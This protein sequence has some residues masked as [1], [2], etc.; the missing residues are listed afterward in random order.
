[1][2]RTGLRPWE[3]GP[4]LDAASGSLQ[5]YGPPMPENVRSAEPA[6]AIEP[7]PEA[8]IA[9]TEAE[10]E[11]AEEVSSPLRLADLRGE[12]RWVGLA[13][14][15]V[16]AAYAVRL[17]RQPPQPGPL[18]EPL[19]WLVAGGLIFGAATAGSLPS[20]RWIP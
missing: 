14:A 6:L 13:L 8:A 16:C 2:G 7:P 4:L 20:R 18:N 15:V 12:L 19:L 5:S 3:G 1:M 11:P 9:M 10:A 17:F